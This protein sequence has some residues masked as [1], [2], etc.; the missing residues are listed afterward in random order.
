ML[1]IRTSVDR[2]QPLELPDDPGNSACSTGSTIVV[3]NG[4]QGRGLDPHGVHGQ[5]L[6]L[7]G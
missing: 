7:Y 1:I 2:H 3:S 4:W 6:P 5:A